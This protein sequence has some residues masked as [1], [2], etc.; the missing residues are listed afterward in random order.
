MNF[1]GQSVAFSLYP[2]LS[3]CLRTSVVHSQASLPFMKFSQP[4]TDWAR[5]ASLIE[6]HCLLNVGGISVVGDGISFA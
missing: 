6:L 2:V 1:G 4:M 3:Y 5:N